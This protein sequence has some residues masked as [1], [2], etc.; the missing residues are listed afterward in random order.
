MFSALPLKNSE[1]AASELT[2]ILEAK[3]APILLATPA[4][5]FCS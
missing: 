1:Q 3:I 2:K 4:T 5:A